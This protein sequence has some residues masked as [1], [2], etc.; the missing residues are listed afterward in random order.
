MAVGIDD[1]VVVKDVVGGYEF[2]VDL[3]WVGGVR[4]DSLS[5]V[6]GGDG[7]REKVLTSR[8]WSAMVGS[9]ASVRIRGLFVVRKRING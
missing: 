7:S 1:A 5:L 9:T 4:M 3:E 8:S 2:A 6:C